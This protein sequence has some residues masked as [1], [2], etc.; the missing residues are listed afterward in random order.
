MMIRGNY[1]MSE[2]NINDADIEVGTD[3]D[4]PNSKLIQNSLMLKKNS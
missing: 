2:E 3:N 1:E 4:S